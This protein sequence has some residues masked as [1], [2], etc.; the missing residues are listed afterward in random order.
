MDYQHFKPQTHTIHVWYGIFTYIWLIYMV[1]VGK[2]TIHTWMLWETRWCFFFTPNKINF[3]DSKPWHNKQKKKTAVDIQVEALKMS[4]LEHDITP[5]FSTTKSRESRILHKKY[6]K[7]TSEQ[8]LENG[9]KGHLSHKKTSYFPLYWL[10]NR[11][12]HNGLL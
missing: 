11:D 4:K 9:Q 5:P 12:P 10:V 6:T 8:Q 1:N 3:R 7:A 2:Y